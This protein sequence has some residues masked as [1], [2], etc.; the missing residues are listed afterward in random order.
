VI[1]KKVLNEDEL[2][3][4]YRKRSRK[5][6]LQNSIINVRTVPSRILHSSNAID[7]RTK[8]DVHST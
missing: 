6:A 7:H 5:L 8:L 2:E 1:T 3:D 4:D